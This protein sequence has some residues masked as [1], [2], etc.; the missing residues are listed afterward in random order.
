VLTSNVVSNAPWGV[1]AASWLPHG[2]GHQRECLVLA[3]TST[4]AG[5]L[6]LLGSVANVIVF[7]IARER[8]AIGFWWFFAIGAPI[9]VLTTAAGLAATWALT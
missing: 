9:T 1:I 7:E 6:T 3:L 2:V 8:C 5:H 4:F